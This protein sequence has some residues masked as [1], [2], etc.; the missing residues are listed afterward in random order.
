MYS[1]ITAFADEL[2]STFPD[3]R[4]RDAQPV[5]VGAQFRHARRTFGLTL[6]EIAEDIKIRPDLLR[7]IEEGSFQKIEEPIYRTL[8]LKNYAEYLGLSWETLASQY[9][10]ES[11]Y[12][13]M[14]GSEHTTNANRVRPIDMVVAPRL[15]KH[16]LFSLGMIG[17]CTYLMV[18]AA[19]ALTRPSLIVSNPPDNAS[20]SSK[21]ISV[22][23]TVSTDAHLSINGQEVSKNKDGNFRQDITL[24][25]GVNV[26]HV[27]AA[28]KYS[29]ET[30]TT[31]TVLYE[32]S[33]LP[34]T[35]NQSD[36]G[37]RSN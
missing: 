29:K 13:S 30:T 17:L 14:Q 23:G 6:D 21:T 15:L 33:T 27:S 9:D 2:D 24:S 31:R 32:A 3:T 22:E 18:L 1:T 12:I 10:R 35:F 37:K 11:V 16:V 5:G 20:S 19:G 25:D 28:K 36:Y 4:T 8:M 26:I 7:A 34:L